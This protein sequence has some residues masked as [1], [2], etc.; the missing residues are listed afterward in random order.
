MYPFWSP[1]GRAIAFFADGQL[2]RID[3]AGGS[4]ITLCDTAEPGG[5][6]W[7]Q[8]GVI[9]FS[10]SGR[11]L[12]VSAAGGTPA[13]L[14]G[15]NA[16]GEGATLVH[17]LFLPDGRRLLYLDAGIRG[18]SASDG[19]IYAAR[20]DSSDRKLLFRAASNVSYGDG[21]LLSCAGRR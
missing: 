9:I 3:V 10:S 14:T 11:L 16:G 21:Y 4:L 6:T 1:N 12:R 15:V 7:N 2:K 8:D 13:P 5:G 18:A 17:P 20:L 19:T